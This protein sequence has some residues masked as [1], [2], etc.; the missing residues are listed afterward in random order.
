MALSRGKSHYVQRG[1]EAHTPWGS[2]EHTLTRRS[3]SRMAG[4]GSRN[5]QV[6]PAPMAGSGSRG[7]GNWRFDAEE[8]PGGG[9][10]HVAEQPHTIAAR[11]SELDNH[12]N[13]EAPKRF[14]E[15]EVI[16]L[17]FPI[18]QKEINDAALYVWGKVNYW[19]YFADLAERHGCR[20]KHKMRSGAAMRK[21]EGGDGNYWLVLSGPARWWGFETLGRYKFCLLYTSPS[22][23]DVEESRMP[24]SA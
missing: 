5:S 2:E 20:V 3:E 8:L 19:Q 23:R 22:P 18:S 12:S 11:H 1:C 13:P 15:S 16:R 4:R 17:M 21:I 6:Q 24:S 7:W 14:P 10:L 9:L